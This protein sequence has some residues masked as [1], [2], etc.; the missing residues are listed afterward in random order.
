MNGL[1]AGTWG[2]REQSFR[3]KENPAHPTSLASRQSDSGFPR[4]R[5]VKSIPRWRGEVGRD[6]GAKDQWMMGEQRTDALPEEN[7]KT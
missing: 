4:L 3:E 2:K 1:S 6:T 7:S 5:H